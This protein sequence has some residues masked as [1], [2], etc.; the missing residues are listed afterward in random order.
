MQTLNASIGPEGA[1]VDVL[2]G[3]AAAHLHVVRSAGQPVP[4]PVSVRG[5][6]DTGAEVSCVDGQIL[7]PLIAVGLAL[8]HFV[9]ANFQP[10]AG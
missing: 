6:I 7:S 8:R 3:L 1:V 9:F 2:V 5:L 10:R 4:A